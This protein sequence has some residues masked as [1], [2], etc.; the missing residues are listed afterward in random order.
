MSVQDIDAVQ[1][2]LGCALPAGYAAFLQDWE[3]GL[4]GA[5]V[6]LYGADSLMERNATYETS[7]SCPGYIAIGDDSGGRAVMLALD[8]EDRAVYLVGHGSMQ[9]DDFELAAADFA[10]WLAA[11]CPVD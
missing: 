11:D 4:C 8:G 6:L 10:A 7:L 3:E 5:Q 2:A 9:R 1:R